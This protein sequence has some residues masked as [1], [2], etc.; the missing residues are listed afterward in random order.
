MATDAVRERKV[1][2]AWTVFD[3]GVWRMLVATGLTVA[4]A[5]FHAGGNS[6]PEAKAQARELFDEMYA[7][8]WEMLP[9]RRG[10]SG[11]SDPAKT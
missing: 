10:G 1:E 6:L 8:S 2:A 11:E 9:V 3:E 7:L 5:T 4:T